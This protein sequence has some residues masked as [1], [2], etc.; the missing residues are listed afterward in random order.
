MHAIVWDAVIVFYELDYAGRLA[1]VWY[2]MVVEPEGLSA[3]EVDS[4]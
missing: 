1:K 3:H 4:P 2:T